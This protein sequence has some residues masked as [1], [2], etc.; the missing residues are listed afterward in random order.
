MLPTV[1]RV[2]THGA[3][4]R[5]RLRRDRI[6]YL[7][8]AP[9]VLMM[10]LVHIIPTLQGLYMS[11]L[12]VRQET[13]RL[14]LRAPFVGLRHYHN[15]L[16]GLIFGGGNANIRGLAQATRNSLWFTL[17]LNVGTVGLGLVLALLLNRKFRGRGLARTLVL[18]PWIVPSFVVGLIWRFIWLQRGGLANQIL[19]E[20]LG[21]V[22]RPIQWLLLENTR[23]ALLLPAVWR[24][25]PFTALL[26][27]AGLQVIPGDLYEA[28]QVDGANAWQRFR[29][30]TLPMLKPNLAVIVMFGVVFNLFGF[31]PYNIATSMFGSTNHG[32]YAELL[33]PAIA[34]Q[35]FSNQL[36]S[37]GAAASVLMMILAMLFILAWYRIFRNAL[38]VN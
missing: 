29:Y 7:F 17:W 31:G 21:L 30:I 14:Y 1:Q 16:E 9:A 10:L 19:V 37:Y 33:I 26:L 28:A 38:T 20:W 6:A 27:L 34:R 15:I 5:Q 2:V 11:L 22:D 12:D 25:V 23:W 36:Y 8:I 3:T 24:N 18:L 4:F 35:T 32:R 13:L